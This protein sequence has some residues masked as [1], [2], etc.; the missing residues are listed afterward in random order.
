M[1]TA[2]MWKSLHT[3]F[4]Y[5][6]RGVL[7]YDSFSNTPL[8]KSPK[9]RYFRIFYFL[10]FNSY[11]I[12]LLSNIPYRIKIVPLSFHAKA[13]HYLL[14]FLAASAVIVTEVFAYTVFRSDNYFFCNFNL[15]YSYQKNQIGNHKSIAIQTMT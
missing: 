3:L 11:A 15:L 9:F 10:Y 5:F 2:K 8:T 1:V 13:I 6:P 4:S 12:G 7:K 14:F